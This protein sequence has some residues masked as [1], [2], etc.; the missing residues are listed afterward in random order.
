MTGGDRFHE[1]NI[2]IWR[3]DQEK[4]WTLELNG[5]RYEGV[6]IEWIHEIVYRALLDAEDDLIES[7]K[8]PPQ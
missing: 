7:A 8:K 4:T 2:K 5:A 1:I 3:N 6:V